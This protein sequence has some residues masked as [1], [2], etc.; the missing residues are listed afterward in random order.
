LKTLVP[1]LDLN[2]PN[3]D[4]TVEKLKSESRIHQASKNAAGAGVEGTQNGENEPESLLESM[5]GIPYCGQV[6]KYGF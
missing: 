2:D 1:D 5:V 6:S 4:V 3:F